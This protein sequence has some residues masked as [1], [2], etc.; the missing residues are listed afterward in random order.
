MGAYDTTKLIRSL[1][2][3]GYQRGSGKDHKF[4]VFFHDGKPTPIKTHVSH[5]K[6]PIREVL[7]G[8]IKKQTH[9]TQQQLNDLYACPLK[10]E[11]I[12]EIYKNLGLIHDV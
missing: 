11:D 3:K 8:P 7:Q 2:S 4:Y 6:D 12:V 9:L 5:S 1:T 10:Y